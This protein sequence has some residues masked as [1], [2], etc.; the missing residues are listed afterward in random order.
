MQL[1]RQQLLLIQATTLQHFMLG[2]MWAKTHP[3]EKML[4]CPCRAK[5]Q[6]LQIFAAQRQ[7]HL[8]NTF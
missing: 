3:Q 6:L 7:I 8:A 2:L 1:W 5:Q 4:N